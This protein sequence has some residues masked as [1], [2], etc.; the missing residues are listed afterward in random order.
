MQHHHLT[1]AEWDALAKDPEFVALLRARR[2]FI[3]PLTIFF[4]LFYLALPVGIALAPGFMNSPLLES[5]SV[6]NIFGFVQIVVALALLA[7]YMHKARSFDAKAQEIV[8]RATAE[9][10]K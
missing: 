7:L 6:A 2:Q 3:V 9:F 10:S 1:A 5:L 8:S 4:L